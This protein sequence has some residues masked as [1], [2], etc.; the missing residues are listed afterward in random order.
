MEI[1]FSLLVI[2]LHSRNLQ[3]SEDTI[4]FENLLSSDFVINLAQLVDVL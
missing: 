3:E 4:V 1:V 2:D